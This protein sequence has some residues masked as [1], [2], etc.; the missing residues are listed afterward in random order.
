MLPQKP[1]PPLLSLFLVKAAQRN[2]VL[3]LHET[4]HSKGVHV[5]AVNVGGYVTETDQT[6]NLTNIHGLLLKHG[7][8]LNSPR[9]SLA[10]KY[11]F[12]K[13]TSKTHQC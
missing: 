6:L 1:E 3:G 10:L 9:T 7:I 2:H 5:G 4:F 11:K 8:D 13:H 12:C